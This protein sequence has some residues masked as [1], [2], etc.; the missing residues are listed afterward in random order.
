MIFLLYIFF[1]V[2]GEPIPKVLASYETRV[3][4]ENQRA[5][6]NEYKQTKNFLCIKDPRDEKLHG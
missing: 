3:L 2:Y 1:N 6:L 4:C 5:I